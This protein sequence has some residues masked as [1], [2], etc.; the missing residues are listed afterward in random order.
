[1]ALVY[2]TIVRAL[3]YIAFCI[4][5]GIVLDI[6][7]FMECTEMTSIEYL[8]MFFVVIAGGFI[9]GWLLLGAYAATLAILTFKEQFAR[10]PPTRAINVL[11]NSMIIGWAFLRGPIFLAAVYHERLPAPKPFPH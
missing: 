1:M 5:Y 7:L 11:M 8:Y 6:S 9:A 4:M 10:N 2:R 3:R